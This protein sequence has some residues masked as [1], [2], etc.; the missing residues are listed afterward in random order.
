MGVVLLRDIKASVLI[1]DIPA[2]AV[3][4]VAGPS[5]TRCGRGPTHG[6]KSQK[7][8]VEKVGLM[9]YSGGNLVVWAAV[10]QGLGQ[11]KELPRV[12]EVPG[13]RNGGA[14]QEQV[15]VASLTNATKRASSVRTEIPVP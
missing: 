12:E 5:D 3:L 4:W 10:D 8:E 14:P 2:P 1:Q 7:G 13:V 11:G 15:L 9:E 6:C